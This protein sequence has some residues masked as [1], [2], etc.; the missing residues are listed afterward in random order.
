M[1]SQWN[2]S[3]L[4]CVAAALELCPLTL[5]PNLVAWCTLQV[6]NLEP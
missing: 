6:R 4:H 1:S 3:P 5:V 2:S